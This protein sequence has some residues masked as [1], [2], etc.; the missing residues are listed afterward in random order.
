MKE[1]NNMN[2]FQIAVKKTGI[3]HLTA[4]PEI[5]GAGFVGMTLS[6][7]MK[8]NKF[9]KDANGDKQSNPHFGKVIKVQT[10]SAMLATEEKI[11]A[12]EKATNKALTASGQDADFKVQAHPYADHVGASAIWVHRD[13]GQAYLRYFPNTKNK[14]NVGYFLDGQLIDWK[15]I[16]G[17]PAKRKTAVVTGSNNVTVDKPQIRNVKVENVTSLRDNKAQYEAASLL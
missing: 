15:D 12:F 6:T 3:Y 5:N 10:I 11:S 8:L 1:A 4:K 16:K 17:T 7:E 9:Y 2:K 14:P 13:N